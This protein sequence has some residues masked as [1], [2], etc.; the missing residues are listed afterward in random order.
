MIEIPE[1]ITIAKQ[2]NDTVKGKKIIEAE[3]GHTQHSFA[4]YHEDPAGYAN[5]M[6]G[7]RIGMAAG[8]GSMIEIEL[9]EKNFVIGDGTN[10]RYYE[11]GRKLPERYQTRLTLE[12]GSSLICTVA[13]Y[14]S[15]F[16][17]DPEVYD[18]FYYLVGKEKPLPVTGDFDYEYFKELREEVSGKNSVKEF[19]A[20]KQRIPGLGNGVLQDIL[21]EAGLHPKRKL[22]TLMEQDWRRMYE[23][24]KGIL[25]K[26]LAAGGRNTEKDLFD[27]PGGYQTLLSKKTVG[28]PCPYCGNLIQKA[29]YLGGTI[30]FCPYCQE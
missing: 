24:I 5:Q 20:T 26:M 25:S 16:L 6:K 7:K 15:M 8:I 2:L 3:A 27:N 29:S 18:N 17:I 13:M 10:I 4:F 9:E 22:N 1:S 19:L 14:G 21:L 28:G 12:D 11:P 23:A 30:Y